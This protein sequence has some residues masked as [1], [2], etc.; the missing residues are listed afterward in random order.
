M[1]AEINQRGRL[2]RHGRRMKSRWYRSAAKS[3][4]R[5]DTLEIAVGEAY[6]Y[7]S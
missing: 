7:R 6:A 1:A 5:G 2:I 4:N 3:I